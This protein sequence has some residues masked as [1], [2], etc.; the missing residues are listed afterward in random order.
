MLAPRDRKRGR[1]RLDLVDAGGERVGG[2][3]VAGELAD[4]FARRHAGLEHGV[5]GQLPG[6]SAGVE[7]PQHLAG[8]RLEHLDGR[9]SCRSQVVG[10]SGQMGAGAEAVDAPPV[11][12]L[13]HGVGNRQADRRDETGDRGGVDAFVVEHSNHGG[14]PDGAG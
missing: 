8:C 11:V 7:L 4:R 2:R 9:A 12:Q 5:G 14:G 13:A 1:V 6:V 10:G 3:G